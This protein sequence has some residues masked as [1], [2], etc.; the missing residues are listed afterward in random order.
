MDASFGTLTNGL[1]KYARQ[2]VLGEILLLLVAAWWLRF[3]QDDAFISFRYAEHWANGHGL[4]WNIGEPPIEGFT[5]LLYTLMIGVMM[6]LGLDPVLASYLIGLASVTGTALGTIRLSRTS[7]HVALALLATNFSFV[8]YATGGLETQLQAALVVWSLA[9]VFGTERPRAALSG[10]LLG[11]AV[12]T[13]LDSVLFGSAIGI[14]LL[15]RRDWRALGTW[16]VALL[17]V[18]GALV[19]FKLHTFGGVLPNTFYAKASGLASLRF[20]NGYEFWLAWLRSYGLI[21]PLLLTAWMTLRRLAWSPGLVAML[22][23]AVWSA[24]V[25][26]VGGDFME[27]RFFVPLF[28]VIVAGLSFALDEVALPW[29]SAV[30]VTGLMLESVGFAHDA[31]ERDFLPYADGLETIRGLAGHI[32]DRGHA[33][34]KIGRFFGEA[35]K[36]TDVTFAVGAAGA[37]PFYSKLRAVDSF[38]LNDKW[39]A[40][41]GRPLSPRPGHSR[42]AQYGY[43]RSQRVN[44]VPWPR[45]DADDPIPSGAKIVDLVVEPNFIVPALYLVPNPAV[46]HAIEERR[47]VVHVQP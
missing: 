1:R 29:L 11:L 26:W 40:R 28:P 44:L 9:L 16:L 23:F 43:L 37:M 6:R 30:F 41:N 20:K 5:N 33:W 10:L 35:F 42:I 25:V 2:L 47:W 3:V 46:D 4:V 15:V 39:I 24:Y 22:T 19:A 8:A 31:G 12:W 14:F 7:G 32:D 13:R 18:F 45:N 21:V 34:A 27:F 36:G 38:G 17:G